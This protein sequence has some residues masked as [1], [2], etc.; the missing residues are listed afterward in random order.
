MNILDSAFRRLSKIGFS[1]VREAQ[2]YRLSHA[3]T[4]TEESP[5]LDV[6]RALKTG[7]LGSVQGLIFQLVSKDGNFSIIFGVSKF[8]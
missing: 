3:G 8:L 5:R 2:N 7:S 1:G 6:S 4:L